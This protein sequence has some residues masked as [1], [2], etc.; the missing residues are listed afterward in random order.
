MAAAI[1][2]HHIKEINI[3]SAGVFATDGSSASTNTVEALREQG[4]PIEHSSKVL[5]RELVEWATYILTMTHSHKELALKKFPEAIGKTF[6]IK[7]F[8]QDQSTDVIDPYGGS[9]EVYRQTY[10]ELN[11]SVQLLVS[12]ITKE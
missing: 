9:L 8:S 2:K 5:T 12:K 4:I 7:E 11:S 10:K 1:A 3:K 6:T